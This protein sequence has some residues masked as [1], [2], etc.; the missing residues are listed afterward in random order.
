[1]CQPS[2]DLLVRVLTLIVALIALFVAS[3]SWITGRRTHLLQV[4][5]DTFNILDTKSM[6]KAR[7]Y[8]YTLRQSPT[9]EQIKQ[10]FLEYTGDKKNML[11]TLMGNTKNVERDNMEIVARSFD[12][13]GLLVREGKV[14]LNLIARFY[15]MPIL[16]C[17]YHLSPYINAVR[18]KREQPGH[19]WEWENLV[20]NIM[21]PNLQKNKGVWKGQMEHDGLLPYITYI[22]EEREFMIRDKNFNPDFHLWTIGPIL[23][24]TK[25]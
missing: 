24:F 2:S 8:V 6:R 10:N 25:W 4:F 21:I 19:M 13:L 9:D 20:F 11:T 22:I 3:A 18:L 12:N 7:R 15:S 17:W 1:M 16:R 14:P 23:D 5:R